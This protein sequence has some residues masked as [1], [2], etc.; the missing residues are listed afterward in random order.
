MAKEKIISFKIEAEAK[1]AFVEICKNK[2]TTA[3]HELQLFV[4]QRIK[5]LTG[6]KNPLPQDYKRAGV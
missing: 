6:T 5:S 2:H 1:E 3:S 4:H